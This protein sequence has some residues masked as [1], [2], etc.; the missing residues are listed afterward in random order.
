MPEKRNRNSNGAL[1]VKSLH[2]MLGHEGGHNVPLKVE[3]LDHALG[4]SG[5]KAK[6]KGISESGKHDVNTTVH[7]PS[8]GAMKS[9]VMKEKKA[10]PHAKNKKKRG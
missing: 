6:G 3:R 10:D 7:I 9:K 8:A 5:G 2:A 1:P 4:K